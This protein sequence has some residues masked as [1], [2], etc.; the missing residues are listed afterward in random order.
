MWKS[1]QGNLFIFVGATLS[2][3][4]LAVFLIADPG[5]HAQ[6]QIVSDFKTWRTDGGQEIT[7]ASEKISV[8]FSARIDY[9]LKDFDFTSD[10][11][12]YAVGIG[13]VVGQYPIF[14][15]TG[16]GGRTW[17]RNPLRVGWNPTGIAFRNSQE[18]LIT[19]HD[20][21]GCPPPNCLHKTITLNTKDGGRSWK[22][23]DHEEL[24]GLITNP[25]TDSNGNYYAAVVLYPNEFRD[26]TAIPTTKIVKSLD[27]GFTWD[28]IYEAGSE[29]HSAQSFQLVED[30]IFVP[31]G[32]TAV[33]KIDTSG[34]YIGRIETNNGK[35]HDFVA[36]S[37]DVVFA[38]TYFDD[39]TGHLVR[40]VNG[41]QSWDVIRHDWPQ[42]VAT[43][44]AD[45]IVV[46]VSKGR[47]PGPADMA[48]GVDAIAYTDN[49]GRTWVESEM[50]R[51][52]YPRIRWRSRTSNRDLVLLND[53]V[54][55]VLTGSR[56]D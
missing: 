55:T 11:H 5:L 18:G 48:G 15:S 45:E 19:T 41:G 9:S 52:F 27:A 37:D 28:V 35:I 1:K 8:D 22:L 26:N 47:T 14:Y 33:T 40:T 2:A 49:G 53:R 3:V 46:V 36:V 38:V 34:D 42:I 54:V 7:F 12:G 21:T 13:A 51:S 17:T 39:N 25:A 44:S 24:R 31:S 50:I 56:E 43:R 30:T 29:D 23:V 6:Q 10:E 4:V 16:D 32:D 20:V